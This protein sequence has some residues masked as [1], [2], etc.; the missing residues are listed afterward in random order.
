MKTENICIILAF[1][2]AY[3]HCSC[4][5]IT[6]TDCIFNGEIVKD[7]SSFQNEEQCETCR[8]WDGEISCCGYGQV[9]RDLADDCKIIKV[10]PCMEEAVL[11]SDESQQ[12][13]Y[14][15]AVPNGRK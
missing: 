8:C 5:M 11:I 15:V 13:S 1:M 10:G 7:G 2:V 6:P 9:I 4:H 14:I 12:C 3:I